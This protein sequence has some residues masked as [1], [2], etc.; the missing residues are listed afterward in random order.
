MLEYLRNKKIIV[1]VAHPDDEVL[2][3][4]GT[5][6]KLVKEWGA[7][8]HVVILGEGLTARDAQRDVKKREQELK[9]HRS[10]ITKA[11]KAIGYQSVSIFNFPDNRFDTVALLDITKTVEREITSCNAEVVFTH[12][13]GDVNVDHKLTF[14]AVMTACRSFPGQQVKGIFSFPTYSG[15]EWIA[16]TEP[17]QYISNVHISLT[18]EDIDAKCKAIE[19]YEFEKRKFPH[20]RS[21]QALKVYAQAEGVKVGVPYAESLCLVRLID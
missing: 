3:I 12:H 17:K 11:K 14:E 15:T 9:I 16:S 8:V 7:R 4:G 6:H 13:N 21:S 20:P 2:G 19:C 1:V 5:I 10:N 18:K